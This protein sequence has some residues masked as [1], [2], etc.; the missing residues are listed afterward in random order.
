MTE[1]TLAQAL[2]EEGEALRRRF[3][4]HTRPRGPLS[5][6]DAIKLS[7]DMNGGQYNMHVRE[8]EYRRRTGL[9]SLHG[10]MVVTTGN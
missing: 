9:M 8:W 3:V 10:P 5:L 7:E 2:A 4:H 1:K 6:E